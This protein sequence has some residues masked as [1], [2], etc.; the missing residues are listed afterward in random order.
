MEGVQCRSDVVELVVVQ[1]GRFQFSR[2]TSAPFGD[3]TA[4]LG[5]N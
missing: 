2:P 5:V 4:G 3:V 1:V